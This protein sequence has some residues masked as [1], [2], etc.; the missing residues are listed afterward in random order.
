MKCNPLRWLWGVVLVFG[1]LGIMHVSGAFSQIEA[2]LRGQSQSALEEAGLGWAKIDFDGRDGQV[3]GRASDDAERIRA[4]EIARDLWGVRVVS[5][6]SELL[7]EQRNYTWGALLREGGKLRLV[8]FVPSENTRRAI[9]GAAKA[10]FPQLEIDDRTRLARGAPESESWLG[11][12]SFGLRQLSWLKTG[13]RIELDAGGLTVEGEAEDYA[14]YRNLRASLSNGLPNGVRIQNDRIVAPLA[15]PYVWSARSGGGQVQ[16]LGHVPS[17]AARERI[18]TAAQKAFGERT[19]VDR[20]QI[21]SGDPRNVVDA[22]LGALPKLAQLEDGAAEL[23]DAQLQISGLAVKQE[24]AEALRASLRDNIPENFKVSDQIKFREPT[25]SVVSPYTTGI[26]VDRSGV[27][28]SGYVPDEA[29]RKALTA[30]VQARFP[31]QKIDDSMETGAGAS[32]GWQVCL[33]AGLDGLAKFGGGSIDLEDRALTF[34]GTTKDEE[35]ADTVRGAIRAAANRACDPAFSIVVD[36]PPEPALNWRAVWTTPDSLVFEG[37]VPDSATRNGLAEAASRLFPSAKLVDRTQVKSGKSKKWPQVGAAGLSALSKLRSGEARIR[38]AELTVT[39]QAPD[40]AVL[41]AVR[42]EI[43]SLPRGYAGKDTIEVRSDA[44]IWAEQEAQ[45]KSGADARRK[46]EDDVRRAAEAAAAAEAERQR[47][48]ATRAQPA[49]VP[50]VAPQA[51]APTPPVA[52][53]APPARAPEPQQQAALQEKPTPRRMSEACRR[54]S[55]EDRG[56]IRFDRASSHLSRPDIALLNKLVRA[57]SACQQMQI[58]VEGHADAEGTPERNQ[59]LSERRADAVVGYLVDRGIAAERV[60]AVGYG[61]T[62]PVAPND[63]PANRAQN[64][65]I[66][67][68]IKIN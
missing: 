58:E 54:A 12:V 43:R 23:R 31:S 3:T 56:L 52:P 9:V 27:A 44:M 57:A 30:A 6:N 46:A 24:T 50:P 59:A 49:P 16:L 26:T 33:L 21:A 11:A 45:K 14:A 36:A 7:E 4:S 18:F 39:G 53:S 68:T 15:K 13:G 41:T 67:F 55:E 47:L 17:E 35:L 34:S 61:A 32:D 20:M 25:I 10:S 1:L 62:R 65:R 63:T 8:G 37:E 60:S 22:A 38:G 48:A 28:L 66:E 19:V 51:Q 42:Q 40:S 2:E 64:R 5:N 29:A